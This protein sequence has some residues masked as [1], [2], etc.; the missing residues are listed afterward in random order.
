M[1]PEEIADDAPLIRNSHVTTRILGVSEKQL[2]KIIHDVAVET[3]AAKKLGRQL[4][5]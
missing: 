5:V 1:P 4:H 3:G 2:R